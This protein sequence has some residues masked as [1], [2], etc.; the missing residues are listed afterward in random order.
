[1]KRTRS[2]ATIA[3]LTLAL[4]ACSSDGLSGQAGAEH[5]ETGLEVGATKE[6]YIAAFEDIEPIELNFQYA[7]T[8]PEAFSAKRDIAW[9]EAVEEWS[10][11]KVTI[12]THPAGA[13]AS[14]TDVPD[15]LADGRLD[16]ANY[17]GTYEPQQMGAFVDLT[18]SLVQQ[19]S[20][21]LIGELVTQA[22]MLDVGFNTEEVMANYEDQGMHVLH[23]GVPSGNI[24][25]MCTE[26]QTSPADFRGT[27]IR[28][29]AQAH[30]VQVQSLG[31]TLTSVELAEG[32]EALER[33]VL[34]CSLNSTAT[35]Y[36][37]GWL[38]VAPFLKMPQEASFAP[39]PG[40]MVVGAKWNS[41]PLVAQQLLFDTM[42][43][44]IGGEHFSAV[45][46][47]VLSA[48]KA[49]DHGGSL[50]YLDPESEAALAEANETILQQVEE[51][52]N[53]DGAALNDKVAESIEKW[54]G[55]AEELGYEE[56]GEVVDFAEWYEGSTDFEDREYLQP[57]ADRLYEEVVL[58]FR[59]S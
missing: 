19:P 55:I 36:N 33:G 24:S 50:E 57:F 37:V 2:L 5:D 35:G 47:V 43:V 31:G 9:A 10:G 26:D 30:E 51:S 28:G 40:S 17:F 21:P 23:P 27:Q 16:I 42:P 58:P 8:N 39:G 59:P 41:L 12:N 14:P 20:S 34:D 25:M 54:T 13:I 7:S 15:A 1:M 49:L 18:K 6:D 45:T 56:R 22:V 48:E 46:S 52:S 44:Y 38:E 3:A 11:G 4:T 32:Y 29:N 53:L